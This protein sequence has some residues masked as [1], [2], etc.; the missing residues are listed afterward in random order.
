MIFIIHK[1][2][3]KYNGS[4]PQKNKRFF[5]IHCKISYVYREPCRRPVVIWGT[6]LNQSLSHYEIALITK[7]LTKAL[8][9]SMSSIYLNENKKR[10]M[11]L[12]CNHSLHSF[13]LD[14]RRIKNNNRLV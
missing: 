4:I 8:S 14:A 7:R 10:V 9:T 1:L 11:V 5:L 2:N 3:Y 13:V 6:C 12:Y